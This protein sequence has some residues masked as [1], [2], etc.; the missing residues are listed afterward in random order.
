MGDLP[1]RIYGEEKAELAELAE[2]LYENL[3]HMNPPVDTPY[4]PYRE[5]SARD[6]HVYEFC[7]LEIL[8]LIAF[9]SRTRPETT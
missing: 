5:L 8:D 2:G 4:V 1:I 7:V 3:I 6:K 9:K